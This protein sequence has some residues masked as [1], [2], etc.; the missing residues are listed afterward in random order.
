MC[1]P[2]ISSCTWKLYL[3][4]ISL[5]ITR[6]YLL[7]PLKK[8]GNHRLILCSHSTWRINHQNKKTMLK[9]KIVTKFKNPKQI[10]SQ[11]Q[12]LTLTILLNKLGIEIVKNESGQPSIGKWIFIS[13]R[14]RLEIYIEIHP[15]ILNH[16]IRN[17]L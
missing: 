8:Q 2:L 13:L 9:D 17:Q 6:Y 12:W 10:I 11:I 14:Y 1:H 5:I 16:F 7:S 15:L 3:E 4:W